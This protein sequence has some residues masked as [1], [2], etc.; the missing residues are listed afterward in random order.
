MWLDSREEGS[1]PRVGVPTNTLCKFG[2][3]E[4]AAAPSNYPCVALVT[5][6]GEIQPTGNLQESTGRPTARW[7]DILP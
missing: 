1:T 6:T 4:V 5:R 3:S 7:E 2:G